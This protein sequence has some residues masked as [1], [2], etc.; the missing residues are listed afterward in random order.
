[1]FRWKNSV[2]NNLILFRLWEC[3][4]VISEEEERV[5]NGESMVIGRRRRWRWS[6]SRNELGSGR[7]DD[8]MCSL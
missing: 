5:L 2:Y 4:I 3:R 6:R 7:Y 8:G 1:M